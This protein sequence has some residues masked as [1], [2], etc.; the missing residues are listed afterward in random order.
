METVT[1]SWLTLV[2]AVIVPMATAAF[3][4]RLHYRNQLQEEKLD[5]HIDREA[6]RAQRNVELEILRDRLEEEI[7]AHLRTIQLLTRSRDHDHTSAKTVLEEEL[8]LRSS[9][10]IIKPGTPPDT[11]SESR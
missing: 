8:R 6:N 10:E 9:Q 2:L 3:L 7:R 1:I 4:V 5:K 11:V